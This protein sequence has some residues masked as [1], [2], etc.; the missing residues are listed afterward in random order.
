MTKHT[1][2]EKTD[3]LL[4]ILAQRGGRA[5]SLATHIIW[6]AA[7]HGL[8]TSRPASVGRGRT[9]AE[10]SN[11]VAWEVELTPAGWER[12]YDLAEARLDADAHAALAEIA[13]DARMWVPVPDHAAR[14]ALRN[15][16]LIEVWMTGAYAS[17]GVPWSRREAPVRWL[18]KL[19][20]R[21][22]RAAGRR[23]AA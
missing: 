9:R 17:R 3:E 23:P 7:R 22:E 15:A 13:A 4:E 14:A 21:G 18:A 16:G 2:H 1:L 11:R 6:P 12:V 20:E 8:V 5:R 19:T 10:P